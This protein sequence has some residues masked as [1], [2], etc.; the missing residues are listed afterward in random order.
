LLS[1]SENTSRAEEFQ[2]CQEVEM[3]ASNTHLIYLCL[4]ENNIAQPFV[5]AST[6]RTNCFT[7]EK[8]VRKNNFLLHFAFRHRRRR[9]NCTRW[10]A[11]NRGKD[12]ADAPRNS[13]QSAQSRCHTSQRICGCKNHDAH[14][15]LEGLNRL[16]SRATWI[17]TPLHLYTHG[18]QN[19]WQPSSHGCIHWPTRIDSALRLLPAHAGLVYNDAWRGSPRIKS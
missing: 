10:I 9:S 16:Q 1:R 12:R 6:S 19:H 14:F 18:D 2:V 3:N 17:R 5:L 11:S 4:Q 7:F 8:R 15:M 13:F